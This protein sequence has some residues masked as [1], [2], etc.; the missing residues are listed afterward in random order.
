VDA[1]LL[2]STLPVRL[3]AAQVLLLAD[4]GALRTRGTA[5][6]LVYRLS[7]RRGIADAYAALGPVAPEASGSGAAGAAPEPGLLRGG[8][9]GASG[10]SRPLT[11]RLLA[12]VWD[13]DAR[14]LPRLCEVIKGRPRRPGPGLLE[15]CD[16]VAARAAWRLTEDEVAAGFPI[17]GGGLEDAGELGRLDGAIAARVGGNVMNDL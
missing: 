4:R 17:R 16:P 8:A 14:T 6:E 11:T 13:A 15:G 10:A 9:G 1:S 3:A 5:S 7:A 2:P 12:G